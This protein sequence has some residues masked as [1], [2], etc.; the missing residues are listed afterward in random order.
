MA[1]THGSGYG[2]IWITFDASKSNAIYGKSETV[3]PNTVVIN[4]WK[5]VS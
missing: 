2:G 1:G 5:R 3:Q 4:V